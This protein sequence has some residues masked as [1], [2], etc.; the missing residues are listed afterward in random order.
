MI[1]GV[2]LYY[3]WFDEY[4]VVIKYS[5]VQGNSKDTCKLF[6]KDG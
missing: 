3:L 5:M 4:E 1:S 6:K 2:K